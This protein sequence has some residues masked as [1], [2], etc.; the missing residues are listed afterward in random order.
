MEGFDNVRKW[1]ADYTHDW[2][3]NEFIP[4]IFYL[5]I[6]RLNF[7]ERLY[8]NKISFDEFKIKFNYHDYGIQSLSFKE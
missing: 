1:K 8:K 5:N 2:I 7:V 4:Y 6:P 3:L